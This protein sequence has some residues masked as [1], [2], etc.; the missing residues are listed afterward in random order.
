M[1]YLYIKRQKIKNRPVYN[2]SAT[3]QHLKLI[4]AK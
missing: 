4:L 1:L 2:L 3:Q